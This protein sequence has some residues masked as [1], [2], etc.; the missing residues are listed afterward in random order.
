MLAPSWTRAEHRR[1]L[2]EAG[3]FD[4]VVV[5]GGVIGCGV[6]L[7]L[8]TRGFRVALIEQ[9]D[10]ASGTS[11]RSTKLFH[12]GIRYLPHFRFQLVAEGLREQR[13]L[14]RI[15]DYLFQTLE[16]VVPVYDQHG[17]AD[18]PAWAARGRRASI[19]LGAGLIVYDLLGGFN[20]PGERHR[21]LALAEVRQAA[22]LLRTEGLRGGFAYSDAQTDDARLVI[23]LARTAVR[24]GCTAVS[25]MEAQRIEETASGFEIDLEDHLDGGRRRLRARAVVS[26][27]GAFRPPPLGEETQPQLVLSKGAHLILG[28]EAVGLLDRAIVL[29]KTDDG[30]VLFLIPWSGHALV[31]TTDTPYEDSPDRPI[32]S[33]EDVEYLLDHVR[34]YLDVKDVSALS[35]FAGLRAL[36]D[37]GAESTAEASREHV[38][39]EPGPG[40]LVVAGGK[41]TTYRRI[42]AEVADQITRFLGSN[43]KSRTKHVILVGAGGSP[44][45]RGLHRYGSEA[46]SVEKILGEVANGRR[47]LSDGVTFL[48]EVGHAVRNESAVSIG[49]FSLRR[50][51]LSLLTA[52]HGRED[53][54]AIAEAM[55]V[56]LGWPDKQRDHELSVFH[57]ELEAEGL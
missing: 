36:A 52:D 22:P 30:R 15:A 29:P 39:T 16:F 6:A 7:D 57:R 2:G 3:S 34:R 27:T 18:A 44:P 8:T 17:L 32:A 35:T 25:R 50:T 26:A 19:A 20:R 37:Q 46:S 11:G 42:A 13:V 48:G 53:A 14:A 47:L 38:I 28:A 54:V 10:W 9:A 12:G 55:Q 4:V 31:G 40:Y 41:L 21:R 23:A 43:S 49:D 5:G 33:A 1:R 51:R 56:E 45:T 24:H